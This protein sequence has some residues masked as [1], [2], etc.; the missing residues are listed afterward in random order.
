MSFLDSYP[1]RIRPARIFLRRA[2]WVARRR[3]AVI[4]PPP[5]VRTKGNQA[6]PTDVLHTP[7]QSDAGSA[8]LCDVCGAKHAQMPPLRPRADMR[9]DADSPREAM[10]RVCRGFHRQRRQRLEC[11][12]AAEPFPPSRRPHPQRTAPRDAVIH[13]AASMPPRRALQQPVAHALA[14]RGQ[15]VGAHARPSVVCHASV[16]WICQCSP[17]TRRRARGPGSAARAL[18]RR[19]PRHARGSGLGQLALRSHAPGSA[20]PSTPRQRATLGSAARGGCRSDGHAALAQRPIYRP[21]GAKGC[22]SP[23]RPSAVSWCV[24]GGA[25]LIH[26]CEASRCRSWQGGAVRARGLL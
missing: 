13:C 9:A 5:E 20:R 23:G 4:R 22:R 3:L 11:P 19:R 2:P 16:D 18:A 1:T 17:G 21:R 10:V 25:S 8:G 15:P 26:T 7:C 14:R 24:T 12:P 6:R